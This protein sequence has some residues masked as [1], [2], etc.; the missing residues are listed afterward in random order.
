MLVPAREFNHLSRFCFRYLESKHT[1]DTHS[2]PM[3]MEHNLDSLFP[4]LVEELLEDMN[5]ELH[6]RVVVVE[7][8]NLVEAGLL[9]FRARLRNDAD[10]GVVACS[11]PAIVA[12]VSHKRKY[13]AVHAVPQSEF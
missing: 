5:D 8:K 7:N 4:S 11:L 10:S 2:V 13:R 9:G 12:R 3:D 1:A 6:R